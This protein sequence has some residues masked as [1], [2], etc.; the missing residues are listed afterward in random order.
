MR[1]S[2]V[3]LPQPLAGPA[4]AVETL[5]AEL[6]SPTRGPCSSVQKDI[7]T[8]KAPPSE[9]VQ[10]AAQLATPIVIARVG[11]YIKNILKAA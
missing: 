10:Q 8:H 3:V 11:P 7:C 9:D 5:P 1:T 2:G 6:V 4:L